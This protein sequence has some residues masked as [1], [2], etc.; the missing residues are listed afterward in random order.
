MPLPDSLPP[1]DKP[2]DIIH[3]VNNMI[4]QTFDKALSSPD[5]FEQIKVTLAGHGWDR[6]HMQTHYEEAKAFSI[7][8]AKFALDKI[9]ESLLEHEAYENKLSKDIGKFP[10]HMQSYLNFLPETGRRINRLKDFFESEYFK[11]DPSQRDMPPYLREK[12]HL[13]KAKE[14][15]CFDCQNSLLQA[16]VLFSNPE[17]RLSF[18][19]D[20]LKMIANSH[21]HSYLNLLIGK[22]ALREAESSIAYIEIATDLLIPEEP[23]HYERRNMVLENKK[24]TALNNEALL[25][26]IKTFVTTNDEFQVKCKLIKT[27]I[28][29]KLDRSHSME[30]WGLGWMGS[31]Y[32]L[33]YQGQNFNVPKGIHDLYML[34]QSPDENADKHCRCV[35]I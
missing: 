7:G 14:A 2:T 33:K 34:V 4:K 35:A 6:L 15:S 11:I 16:I 24:E 13:L 32:T 23:S 31:R 8:T 22:F 19:Q 28:E 30:P 18:T 17:N 26:E 9:L 10:P 27:K 3:N 29:S 21:K 5:E 20:D 25:K 1:N 12:I